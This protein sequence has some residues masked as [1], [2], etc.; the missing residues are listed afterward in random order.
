MSLNTTL[1]HT[2]KDVEKTVA[3]LSRDPNIKPVLDSGSVRV[4][5]VGS[6]AD[7]IRGTPFSNV[8]F[9]NECFETKSHNLWADMVRLA[10]LAR[11]GGTYVGSQRRLT[12]PNINRVY[13][14]TLLAHRF[15]PTNRCVD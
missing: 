9:G 4:K 12:K 10:L 8:T 1:A 5:A 13:P 7:I 3:I 6:L 14:A 15:C 11:H 2:H